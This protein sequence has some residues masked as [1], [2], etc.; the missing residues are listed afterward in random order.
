MISRVADHCFWF[1]RYVER[2][3]SD[4]A[5]ARGDLGR[6]RSTPSCPPPACWRPVIVVSGEEDAFL[7]R[8]AGGDDEAAAWGDGEVVQRF[9]TWDEDNGVS[10]APLGLAARG[11]TRAR[12]AR[13]LSLE[14]WEA[15]NE[16]HLWMRGG[17]ARETV[18]AASRGVLPARAPLDAAHARAGRARRCS[19]TS[20]STSSGSACCSSA[21][22][23]TARM[24]DVHHHAFTN[25][26]PRH[27]VVETALWLSLLRGLSGFEAVHEA[28]RRPGQLRGA[29]RGS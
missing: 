1:G 10:L 28:R 29:S 2:A 8:I 7:S 16:L 6:S 15:V 26:S 25:L 27:E 4:R 3:E 14:A 24:L 17:V 18:R 11:G 13:S 21:S 9:M 23:Q 20:R 19:T 12:S 22:A 5:H